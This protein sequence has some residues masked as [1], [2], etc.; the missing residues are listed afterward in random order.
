METSPPTAKPTAESSSSATKPTGETSSPP[1]PPAEKTYGGATR[2]E[3][4]CEFVSCLANPY[5]LQHLATTKMFD[6][7]RF[8]AYLAYL[9]YWKEPPYLKYLI[10]PGPTLKH[11]EL[12]QNERFRREIISPDVVARLAEEGIRASIELH[13]EG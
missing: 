2:F 8:V 5:Y 13:R 9:L 1:P 7:A 12:L 11:L 10:Y 3:I 4:E 6:D